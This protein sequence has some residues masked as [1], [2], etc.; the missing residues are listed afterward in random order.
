MTV[1]LLENVQFVRVII[2]ARGAS[3]IRAKTILKV[4]CYL[5]LGSD[6]SIVLAMNLEGLWE[7]N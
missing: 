4:G 7:T 2:K 1:K 3:S 5:N 6:D